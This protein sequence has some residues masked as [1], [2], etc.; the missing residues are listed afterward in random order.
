M[1]SISIAKIV[2]TS[3]EKRWSQVHTFTPS[4]E[5]LLLYG[6]LILAVVVDVAGEEEDDLDVSL[7]GKEVIQRFHELYFGEEEFTSIMTHLS[8]TMERIREEFEGVLAEVIAGVILPDEKGSASGVLYISKLGSGLVL[9]MRDKNVYRLAGAEKGKGQNIPYSISGY[10]QGKDLIF[11]GT[12]GLFEIVSLSKIR[13]SLESGNPSEASLMLA[14]YVHGDPENN[15]AAAVIALVESGGQVDREGER[16]TWEGEEKREQQKNLI[17]GKKLGRTFMLSQYEKLK[18]ALGSRGKEKGLKAGEVEIKVKGNESRR[19]R[20]MLSV[21]GV[22]L[23]MLLLSVFFGFRHRIAKEREEKFLA[24]WEVVEHQYNEAESLVELNPLRARSLLAEARNLIE[25][26]LEGEKVNDLSEQQTDKLERKLEEVR[27]LITKVSGE[28]K[29]EERSVFLNL[30]LVRDNTRGTA[31]ALYE[32]T[33]VVLD[34]AEAVLV[35]VNTNNRQSDIVGGGSLL[36]G[37][38]FAAVAVNRGFVF[39]DSGVIE[40][41]LAGKTSAV[42]IEKDA[43]W[44]QIAAMETFAGNLYLLDK[45]QSEI[46]RYQGGEGG[47]GARRRWLGEG[48]FPDLS[49]AV[50]MAIDGDVWVLTSDSILK[51][52]R[53][54]SERFSISGLEKKLN[55]PKG[56]FTDADSEGVYV[57]DQGNQRAV[58]FDKNGEYKAQYIW[59]GMGSVSDLVVE[60]DKGRMLL[61]S[62]SDILE[63]E[64]KNKD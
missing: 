57:L 37:S 12:E 50:D 51:F 23:L 59:E 45:G 52:R 18:K 49:S 9:L 21:A 24:I 8:A 58:V 4:Q 17:K 44:G 16:G 3:G 1:I 61:L 40:V 29:L 63:I 53:G 32:N 27:L 14:P 7:I 2:G 5:K 54:A 11:L 20:L 31:A 30:S 10:V 55:N 25:Q 22:I 13:N 34:K 36:N 15:R 26:E 43:E 56:I 39:S 35:K 19:S 42:V 46:F 6:S 41:S 47:F 48:V 64:L 60:E 33:L 38:E 28:Y 62:G